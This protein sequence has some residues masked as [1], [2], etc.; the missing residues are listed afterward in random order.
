MTSPGVIDELGFQRLQG[1]FA[2]RFYPAVTTPMTRARYLIFIPAIYR[3]MEIT[4][5]ALG[6]DADRISRD[7]QFDLRTALLKNEST[8]IGKE[9][10]RNIVRTPSNIYWSALT[11]LGVATQKVSEAS[12]QR[13]LSSGDFQEKVTVDDDHV[14]HPD[15]GSQF[16]DSD[17]KLAHVIPGHSFTE[18]TSFSLRKS[19]AR[20]LKDRY[21]KLRPVES[22]SLMTHLI[23]IAEERGAEAVAQFEYPWDVQ[24]LPAELE[25]ATHQAR[26]L[27]LFARGATIQYHHMLAEKRGDGV[28]EITEAF[29][30]WRDEAAE[31]LDRWLI[32]GLFDLFKNWKVAGDARDI[33]FIKDWTSRCLRA[34]SAKGALSDPAAQKIIATREHQMRPGR[35]RLR[36]KAQLDSWRKEEPYRHYLFQLNYRHSVGRTIAQDIAE[37]LRTNVT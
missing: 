13:R 7:L 36:V 3:H 34:A 11:R 8:A 24:S 31:S 27:S 35:E 25:N 9:G 14:A 28:S 16:W 1:P 12:Y 22:P 20:F 10:G 4:G 23:E 33:A 29:A 19:E 6:K 21:G 2:E 18:N 26:T 15:G 30:A 32:D 37:G 17:L 5:L